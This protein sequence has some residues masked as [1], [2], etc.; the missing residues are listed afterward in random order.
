MQ[1]ALPYP[2]SSQARMARL[3]SRFWAALYPF[4]QNPTRRR[5]DDMGSVGGMGM[6]RDR[7]NGRVREAMEEKVKGLR[8]QYPPVRSLNVPCLQNYYDTWKLRQRIGI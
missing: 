6:A 5:D 3:D 1:Y 7:R 8:G 2:Y 4:G